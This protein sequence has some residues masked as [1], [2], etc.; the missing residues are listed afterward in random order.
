MAV[1]LSTGKILFTDIINYSW[2]LPKEFIRKVPE[3]FKVSQEL[4]FKP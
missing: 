1:S 2:D 4:I 3:R